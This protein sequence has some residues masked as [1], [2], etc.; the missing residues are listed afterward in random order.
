MKV[1]ALIAMLEA[2]GWRLVR[3]RGSHR[4]FRHSTKAG[5]ITVAGKPSAEVP[6]GT[7]NVILER[8]ELKD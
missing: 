4:Q 8:A 3:T 2:D 1:G 7:L 5:T 6:K